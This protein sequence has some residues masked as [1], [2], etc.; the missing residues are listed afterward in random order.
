MANYVTIANAAASLIGE[1]DQISS[2]TDDTHVARTIRAV[3]D[4]CREAAIRDHAWNFAMARKGLAAEVLDDVPYP[5]ANSFRLPAEC[6]RL[7][8]VLNLSDNDYQLEG[9]SILCNNDGP[10][11]VRYLQD[12]KEP[13]LWDDQFA[14]AFSRLLAVQIGTR[15]A[16]SSY[17][18]KTGWQLYQDALSQAKRVDAR[19]N[20]PVSYEPTG[21]ELARFGGLGVA[22]PGR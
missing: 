4:L 16:G 3:W 1:D 11:Y 8:E 14:L 19:E 7:I 12:V 20:P 6:L 15:I 22:G 5:W 17:D 18:R 13:A 9:R 21:W 10:V 2:P